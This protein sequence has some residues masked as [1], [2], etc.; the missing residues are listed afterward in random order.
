MIGVLCHGV[1]GGLRWVLRAVEMQ[2]DGVGSCFLPE[3]ANLMAE[4]ERGKHKMFGMDKTKLKWLYIFVQH[5]CP[6]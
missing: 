3:A 5:L 2:G 6:Q 4:S 1:Q